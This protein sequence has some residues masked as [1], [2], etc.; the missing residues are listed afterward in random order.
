[1]ILARWKKNKRSTTQTEPTNANP[2]STHTSGPPRSIKPEGSIN[3]KII[4]PETRPLPGRWPATKAIQLVQSCEMF[5]GAM[6]WRSPAGSGI[7]L[8]P[9]QVHQAALA[10]VDEDNEHIATDGLGSS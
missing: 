6:E 10:W 2:R 5:W 4:C 7:E 3:A 1:L 9:I 8:N